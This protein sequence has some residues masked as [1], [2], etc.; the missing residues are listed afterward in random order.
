M[1][2]FPD[3]MHG[4]QIIKILLRVIKLLGKEQ[5]ARSDV[6]FVQIRHPTGETRTHED[7]LG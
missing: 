6:Q 4:E 2:R 7:N 5:R 3:K 1:R